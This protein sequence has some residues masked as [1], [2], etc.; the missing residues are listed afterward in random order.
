[1]HLVVAGN[2]LHVAPDLDRVLAHAREL[3]APGGWLVA[4]EA[5]DQLAWLD[6]TTMLL[7]DGERLTDRWRADHALLTPS[8]WEQ[9]LR[10]HGFSDVVVLP[11]PGSAAE[12]LGHHVLLARVPGVTSRVSSASGDDATAHDGVAAVREVQDARG[13]ADE[14]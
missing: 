10:A 7:A 13:A 1:H 4:Y 9:A 12:T 8:Q 5:T 3:L 2:A 6:V 14:L 11:D